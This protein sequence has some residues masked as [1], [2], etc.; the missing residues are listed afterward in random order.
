MARKLTARILAARVLAARVL[1]ARKL[2]ARILAARILTA[3]VLAARVLVARVLAARVLAAR[4]LA[5]RVLAAHYHWKPAFMSIKLTDCQSTG[6]QTLPSRNDWK[7]VFMII[8]FPLPQPCLEHTAQRCTYR[9]KVH[10]IS[11]HLT[12]SLAKKFH[13]QSSVTHLYII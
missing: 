3:R 11:C 10:G 1:A 5:G 2:A 9:S 4:V 12:K 6:C 13:S 8:V 7:P